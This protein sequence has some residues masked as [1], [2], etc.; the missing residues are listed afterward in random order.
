MTLTK[1]FS[2]I[3]K[4]KGVGIMTV[5]KSFANKLGRTEDCLYKWETYKRFPCVGDLHKLHILLKQNGY[6]V[7]LINLFWKGNKQNEKTNKQRN[8]I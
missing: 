8:V 7:D 4:K 3:A 1:Y 5:R 6:D 2:M